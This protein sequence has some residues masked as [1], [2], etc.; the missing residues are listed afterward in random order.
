MKN[1]SFLSKIEELKPEIPVH[2]EVERKL[3]P[4]L[5]FMGYVLCFFCLASLV[6]ALTIKEETLIL[7]ESTEASSDEI[8][9]ATPLLTDDELELTAT[10]VLNFYAISAVFAIV[11]ASCFFISWKKRKILFHQSQAKE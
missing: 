6:F 11:G 8:I 10:E 7:P 9:A 3:V 5:K 1:K 2:L 4:R